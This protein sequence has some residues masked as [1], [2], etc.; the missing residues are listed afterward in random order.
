MKNNKG[1]TL[2]ALIITIIIMLILAAVSISIAVNGGLFGYAGQAKEETEIEKKNE[3]K[4]AN[5][6]DN[7]TYDDLILKYSILPTYTVTVYGDM[8]EDG[9]VNAMDAAQIKAYVQ[10]KI[11]L[12]PQAIVNADVNLDGVIDKVVHYYLFQLPY[13]FLFLVNLLL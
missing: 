6:G 7:M 8:N 1:I 2:I 10:D 4:Y 9:I 5:L 13:H 11:Q 3:L 12:S